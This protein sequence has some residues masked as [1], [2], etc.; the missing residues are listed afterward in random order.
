MKR[1]IGSMLVGLSVS[2]SGCAVINQ[3]APVA[4]WPDLKVVEHHVSHQEMRER[5]VRFMAPGMSPEGCTLFY[6]D[7][8]EAHIYVSKDFPSQHVLQHER[9][10]AAGY[11]HIGSENMQRMLA[12]WKAK[13]RTQQAAK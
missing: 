6:L 10:H 12:R 8:N 7:Q 5:C 3:H 2:L 4:G 11:D 13:Q 1:I 9:L